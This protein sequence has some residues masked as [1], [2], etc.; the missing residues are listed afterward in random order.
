MDLTLCSGA[1]QTTTHI[2]HTLIP[3]TAPHF[4]R[5]LWGDINEKG[6]GEIDKKIFL[7]NNNDSQELGLLVFY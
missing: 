3:D 2:L 6:G 4:S 1:G 5:K 7:F